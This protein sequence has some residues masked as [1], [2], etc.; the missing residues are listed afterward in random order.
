MLSLSGPDQVHRLAT[1]L[2]RLQKNPL[3][4]YGVALGGVLIA[5]LVRWSISGVVHDRIPFT[6]YYPAIMAATLVGGFWVG[7]LTTLLS[8]FIAWWLFFFPAFVLTL[9]QAQAASLVTFVFVSLLL[10]GT[11]TALNSAIDLLLVEIEN[12]RKSQLAI[13]QLAAVVETS[14]DGIITIDLN[15]TITSWNKGAERIYGYEA[16]EV[17]GKPLNLLIPPDRPDE[18]PLIL[19][20][21]RHGQRIEHYETVRLCKDGNLIDVSLSVSPLSDATGKIIG[22]SKIARD[23][24]EKKRADARQE[25]LLKEM[26]HRVKNAFNVVNGIVAMSARYAQPEKLAPE[27]QSRLAALARA[28][29]LTRPGLLSFDPRQAGPTSFRALI[30]T[31]FAP[32]VE[33]NQSTQSGRLIVDGPD[34]QIQEQDITGLALVLYE[35][36]TNSVKWGSFSVA[37]GTVQIKTAIVNGILEIEWKERGGPELTEAPNHEGFGTKLVKRTVKDQFGGEVTYDWGPEGLT[38]RLTAFTERLLGPQNQ[39]T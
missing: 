36:A 16:N 38:I 14:Q 28:H 35:L 34:V 4:V 39:L 9:N 12:R 17:F 15:G 3:I 33:S 13:E 30:D 5:T 2:H 37:T 31:I 24:S 1:R 7:A 11:V 10:V 23:I 27:I 21:L 22:A 6:T 18:E 29:D 26:S 25:M 20:R 19:E 32:Y 8:A